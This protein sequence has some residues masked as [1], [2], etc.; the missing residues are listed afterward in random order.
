MA[1]TPIYNL[2]DE[3][4]WRG[5]YHQHTPGIEE[6]LSKEQVNGYVGF[7]PTADSL[8]IGNLVPIILLMHLQ[9]SGHRPIALIGG[10]TGMVGDPSGKRAER[11]LLDLETLNHNQAC[12]KKQ[13][14]QFLDF[15][16]ENAAEMA[17][18]YDW[19]QNL[20]FLEFIRD[21]GKHITVNYM[22]AKDS[23][24]NRID[25]GI[26][27]TE[28]SYQLVQGYDFYHLNEHKNCK[29]QMGG[30]DQW[31]NILTGTEL[32]RRKGGQE[33]HAITAPL[34]TKPD[35]SKFG[36]S[37]GGNVWL[38]INKTSA[39][40]FYQFWLNSGDEEAIKLIKIFTFLE[41]ETIQKIV[42]EHTGNEHKR[43]LQRTL[44]KEVTKLVHGDEALASAEH[45]ST[46]LFSDNVIAQL[47]ELK[48]Q[49][50][51]DLFEGENFQSSSL[52]TIE[53]KN[54]VDALCEAGISSSKSEARRDLKGN[55]VSVNKEKVTEEFNLS[56]TL[57]LNEKYM[58]IE[59]GKKNKFLISIQ[60]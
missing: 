22:L 42:D 55:A 34:L 46:I 35:G 53:G 4:K 56:S 39:Y 9:R 20:G 25:D 24:K 38:D 51:L 2:L 40:T 43:H 52:E 49:D 57:L 59:K 60:S 26:S 3:L 27:F 37:E 8:H 5:L 18:N 16:G 54:I 19:F 31:G 6:L 21:I 28:F 32:I 1:F 44:A 30:S 17:N 45:L 50:F 33:A 11:T 41:R 23:V 12:Q 58:L 10:A 13:L 15:E 29:L 36:K 48:E 47:K 14:E 7:D